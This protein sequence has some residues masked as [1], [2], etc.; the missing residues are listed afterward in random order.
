LHNIVSRK[1]AITPVL[2][3]KLE[4]ALGS[5]AATWLPMQNAYDLA[6]VQQRGGGNVV[7]RFTPRFALSVNSIPRIDKRALATF[8]VATFETGN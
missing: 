4:R 5:S 1:S 3:V 7:A 8:S 2:A 6:R